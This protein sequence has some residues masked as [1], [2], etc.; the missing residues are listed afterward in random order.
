M[1]GRLYMFWPSRPLLCCTNTCIV[2][3]YEFGDVSCAVGGCWRHSREC[4]VPNSKLFLNISLS[5]FQVKTQDP[6]G[7]SPSLLVGMSWCRKRPPPPPP[8][9]C[10]WLTTSAPCRQPSCS[11]PAPSPCSSSSSP[12]PVQIEN[13]GNPDSLECWRNISV[14]WHIEC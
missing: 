14:E 4:F 13:A 12:S 6:A 2:I 11:A 5:V 7:S 1:S 10:N 8:L 9:F 3:L